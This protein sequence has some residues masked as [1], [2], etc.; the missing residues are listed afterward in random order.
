MNRSNKGI[1][2][3]AMGATIFM[4]LY[5][6]FVLGYN[7]KCFHLE[8]G[9]NSLGLLM[10]YDINDV[11]AFFE[12]RSK[13]QLVCYREFLRYYDSIFPIIYTAMYVLWL[14]FLLTKWRMLL[15]FPIAHMFLD[16]TENY[17]EILMIDLYL[18]NTEVTETLVSV[19]S[20]VTIVKWLLSGATYL[21]LL[22]GVFLRIRKYISGDR[23][24]R[25][26]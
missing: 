13:E 25:V 11:F 12:S 5:A 15:I 23:S 8:E 9:A 18:V 4:V 3:A 17:Y 1:L 16:W 6:Q 7:S 14:R 10:G 26:T 20:N 24:K 22:S 21:I 19:A 2:Y